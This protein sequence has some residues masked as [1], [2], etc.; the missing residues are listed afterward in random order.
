MD[1]VLLVSVIFFYALI[2]AA[3]ILAARFTK[4]RKAN[5]PAEAMIVGARD[6]G[7]CLGIFTVT[8]KR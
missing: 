1:V 3:G 7:L 6:I 2:A 8:G 4:N 5:K